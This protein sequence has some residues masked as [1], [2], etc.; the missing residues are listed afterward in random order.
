MQGFFSGIDSMPLLSDAKSRSISAE[1]PTGEPGQGAKATLGAGAR[2]AGKLGPG[3]KIAPCR[4]VQPGEVFTM[5][6][7]RGSGV[8]ESMWIGGSVTRDFILRMYWD[9]QPQCCVECPLPDFFAAAWMNNVNNF[10]ESP[11]MQLNSAMIAVNPNK[12]LNCF[13]KMP[14]RRHAVMTVENRADAVRTIFYQINYALCGVPEDAAYFHAQFRAATPLKAGEDYTI[15]DGVKGKG[16]YVG[17]AL[18]VG[19]NGTGKWWGE[20]EVKFYMDGDVYPTIC[21]TGTEDYFLGSYDWDVNGVYAP[22]NSLY[23]GMY[24]VSQPKHYDSQ[25][26]FS[27]YRWHVPDPVRFDRDLKVTIQDLGWT[28]DGHYKPRRDDFYSVAYWYQTLG[29]APFPKLPDPADLEI[30]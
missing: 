22:Y 13:W 18:H 19:L 27:M 24:Y 4:D 2:C 1:N 7:I 12:A 14:F 23:A 28:A 26:R 21:G 29:T 17:T 20:G 9:D 6:D 10:F 16:Q 15:L 25:M 5:A 8:I 11:F 3:W 30:C